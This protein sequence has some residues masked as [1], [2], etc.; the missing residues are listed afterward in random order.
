[1]KIIAIT[2]ARYGSTRLPGK[3]LKTAGNQSLLEIHL[4]RASK[5]RLLNK[6]VVAT[7]HEP[8]A[9]Q[10]A[11]IAQRAGCSVYKGDIHDVLDRFYQ[12]AKPENPDYV[13]RITSD[14]PLIDPEVIDNVIQQ[15]LYD[16]ADYTSNTLNPTFPDGVDVEVFT[17]AAL[18]KAW[19]SAQLTSEREHVTPFIWKN[20]TFKGNSLFTATSYEN[21]T[22]FSDYRITV[23]EEADYLLI[24]HL[25][26]ELGTEKPWK[27]YI[28][29]L[30]QSAA[31]HG[32]NAH[33]KRNEGYMKTIH[34]EVELRRITNFKKSDEYR[35][36]IHDLIPGG[37]HTYS[38]GDDQFPALSPAAISYGKGV[39]VWDID[40]N[41]FLD[42][43][44]GLTSVSLGH[45]YE[46]VNERVKQEV[47]RG[48]NFQRPAYIEME[49]AEKFLSLLP[50]HQ[51]I[52]FAKNGSSVTT[53][54]VKIA[55][56]YTGRKLVA[57]P[58]DHPFYSYDDWFIGKTACN[59]GVPEEISALSVTYK[60]DDIDSLRSLFEQYPGQIACVISEPEKNFGLPENYLK[61]A[62]QLAHKHGALYIADEMIT[63]FKTAF[64]GSIKKYNVTPDMATWGKGI[65]NGYSFCA[66]TGTKEVMELGGIRKKGAQKLFLT[67]T[68]HGGE[69]HVIAAGLATIE[70]FEKENVV[71]HNHTIGNE[72]LKLN[73]EAL[74]KHGLHEYIQ[75]A[76]C[77]WMP[78]FI[79]KNKKKEVC[80]S[81]RT[82][83]LQEMIAR[84]VL[85]QGA[86]V[87]CFSHTSA[88]IQY[89]AAAF[90]E[91]LQVF[92][93]A[94]DKGYES[95][96]TG[97]PA[98]PVFRKYL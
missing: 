66:L 83:M 81:M 51:M 38:K 13:V 69:T 12:A 90:D 15:C 46:P 10:I 84:G 71:A 23:D 60:A 67:S 92:S 14:C 88:D 34:T 80:S 18:E 96:L 7:T 17:F 16:L 70:V 59:F 78:I 8:Q 11:A 50:C 97:E 86:F 43:S 35:S 47:D 87:P 49:M 55:R 75:I 76:D 56:A 41:K 85:F 68:T 29:Y 93:Q 20:S 42:C 22:D 54:A 39:H 95:F 31:L 37:A 24:K 6:I 82:L 28:S 65:A 98:K 21:D 62:I 25:V 74:S 44:M 40:G 89:F 32:L 5:A 77:N 91:S 27:E 58:Y 19:Q 30:R 4:Q 36:K 73:Q 9:E 2:Q 33:I 94:L 64:P 3:V 72:F 52:K 79:F 53:A 45:A 48:V 26:E 61:N 1:M 63:G 57:F